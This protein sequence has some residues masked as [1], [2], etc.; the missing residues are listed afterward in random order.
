MGQ[1]HVSRSTALV[2]DYIYPDTAQGTGTLRIAS[3]TA[4]D[5]FA[6]RSIG[7]VDS[8]EPLMSCCAPDSQKPDTCRCRIESCLTFLSSLGGA[9]YMGAMGGA[10]TSARSADRRQRGKQRGRDSA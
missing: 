4:Y 8:A 7:K 1:E 3:S 6:A 2:S 10:R 5:K 9:M